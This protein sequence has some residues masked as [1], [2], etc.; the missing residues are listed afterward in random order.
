MNRSKNSCYPISSYPVRWASS[1]PTILGSID[2]YLD[3]NIRE[4]MPREW[5]GIVSSHNG[6]HGYA[7]QEWQDALQS[8]VQL[9]LRQHWGILCAQDAPYSQIILHACSRYSVPIRVVHTGPQCDEPI[10]SGC[11]TLSHKGAPIS[12]E[13]S[14]LSLHDRATVF[15]CDNLF[16]LELNEGGKIAQLLE[17][18]LNCE[19]IP[20]GSSYLSIPASRSEKKKGPNRI[21]WLER[22]VIGWLNIKTETDPDQ[23]FTTI[24][25]N[26]GETTYQPFLS[27]KLLSSSNSKYLIH[28]TRSRRGPWPDQSIAQFHDELLHRPWKSQP[29]VLESLSRILQQRRLIATNTLRRG[30]AATV[31]FSG[32]SIDD[33][34]AMRRFRSHL[35][36][37]DWEPYG[38]MIEREWLVQHGAKQVSY[39]D[40][41]TAK[42]RT[43]EELAFC[44][45]TSS[46][47]GSI[48]WR[49]EHEWRSPGDL[50]LSSIPFSKAIVFV[51][52]LAEAIELQ[53]FSFW[54]IAIANPN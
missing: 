32:N 17:Q 38:I 31:C 50:R 47:S 34:L 42:K 12:E 11:V 35:A 52:T 16:V 15:L 10:P 26:R 6:K 28:C 39:I 22:G 40:R 53:K 25:P 4:T 27:I 33:L 9:A 18:R 20:R 41:A 29:T 1:L 45:I 21:D 8:A 5:L 23:S 49:E 54:P 30:N 24:E 44:Q 37:W 43:D 19:A 36:R 2:F 14:E 13:K 7:T 48:D 51:A 3:L 46:E